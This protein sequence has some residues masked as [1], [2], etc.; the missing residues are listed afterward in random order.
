VNHEH[1]VYY[2]VPHD[3]VGAAGK[4][5]KQ[6]SDDKLGHEPWDLGHQVVKQKLGD[7]ALN[8]WNV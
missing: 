3:P 2:L 8:L 5:S 7:G 4:E 1:P 6:A